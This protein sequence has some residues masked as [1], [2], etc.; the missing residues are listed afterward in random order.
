ME[1]ISGSLRRQ[2]GVSLIEL[3]IVLALV[4]LVVGTVSALV[5]TG[6]RAAGTTNDFLQTQAQAR[7]ALDQ[8]TDEV[9][10]AEEVTAA[11]ATAL[12]VVVPH[13]TPFA[14]SGP[15]AVTFAYDAAAR[16]ITRQVDPDAAGPA[17]FGP[18]IPIAY[19]VVRRDA[20]AGVSFEYYNRLAVPLGVPPGDL[21]AVARVRIVV[22]TTRNGIGRT[23]AGDVALRGRQD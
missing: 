14:T 11:S 17:E 3:L 6:V 23:M 18:V 5:L 16:A 19:L 10:W 7:A 9:R 4:S 22:S 12:T 8:V 13:S 20:A 21:A 15:Y 1:K 2:A